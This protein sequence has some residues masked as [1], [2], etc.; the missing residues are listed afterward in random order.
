[1]TAREHA[2]LAS[3]IC[4]DLRPEVVNALR[5]KLGDAEGIAA[6]QGTAIEAIAHALT[7]IALAG[8]MDDLDDGLTVVAR[9]Y[10]GES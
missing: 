6:V 7:A 2:E 3:S 10:R 8:T 9:T 1:M 5:A 4:G